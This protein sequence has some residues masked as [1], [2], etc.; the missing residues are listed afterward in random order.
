MMRSAQFPSRADYRSRP[1]A[2]ASNLG[3]PTFDDRKADAVARGERPRF[4]DRS[5]GPSWTRVCISRSVPTGPHTIMA[6]DEPNRRTMDKCELRQYGSVDRSRRRVRR[7]CNTDT[8]DMPTVNIPCQSMTGASAHHIA[9]GRDRASSADRPGT[10]HIW[11]R[12]LIDVSEIGRC[13]GQA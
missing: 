5:R 11:T 10:L 13:E 6:G 9:D 1:S 4:I 7:P 3:V 2:V 8:R 12:T